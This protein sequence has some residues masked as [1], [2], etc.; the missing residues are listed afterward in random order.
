MFDRTLN[1]FLVLK[2][3][4]FWIQQGSEIASGYEYARVLNIPSVL[5]MPGLHKEY[6]WICLNDSEYAMLEYTRIYVNKLKSVWMTFILH[7]PIV[8]HTLS[9]WLSGYLLHLL[10]NTGSYNSPKKHEAVFLKRQNLIFSIVAEIIWWFFVL[11]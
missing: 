9:I 5:L 6:A 7:F 4:E 2:M 3:L 11:D 10:H 8:I 1:M